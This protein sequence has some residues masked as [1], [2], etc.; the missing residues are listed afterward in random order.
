[1]GLK[2]S[3]NN[4]LFFHRKRCSG[5]IQLSSLYFHR[6]FSLAI[7]QKSWGLFS[8]QKEIK[9][10]VLKNVFSLLLKQLFLI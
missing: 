6:L 9:K 2:Q 1:M 4:G 8:T 5:F 10:G 3:V 7:Y